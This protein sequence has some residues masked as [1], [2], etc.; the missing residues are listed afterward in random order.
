MRNIIWGGSI[1]NKK[2]VIVAWKSCCKRLNEG[3]LGIFSLRAY[4]SGTNMHLCRIFLNSNQSWCNLLK[5]GVKRNGKVIKYSIKSSIWIGIKEAH[6]LVLENCNWIIGN[7]KNVN[8]WLDNW[9]GVSLASKYNIP[10]RFHRTL[11]FV[12]SDWWSNNC[13]NV[14]SNTQLAFPSLL[15]TI[16]RFSILDIDVPD[17]LVWRNY[18]TCM[19]SIKDAYKEIGKPCP[20]AL[21]VDFLW[22]RGSPPSHS[23]LMW[24]FMHHKIPNDE[25]LK[26]RG[27][28]F[29]SLCSMCRSTTETSNQLFFDCSYVQNLWNWLDNILQLNFSIHCLEDCIKD[30]HH[31]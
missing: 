17:A 22:D 14:N 12:V 5:V 11:T 26:L 1:D 30:M 24:I 6:Q 10:Y 2:L 27:F 13:W 4:K 31:F 9:L 19:L 20:S 18:T 29:P 15:N 7:G 21:W 8:F 23:M 3:G 16:S 28:S 25:N